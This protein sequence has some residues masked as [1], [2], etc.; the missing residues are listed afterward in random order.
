MF[1]AGVTG[2]S[3]L[4]CLILL[5]ATGKAKAMTANDNTTGHVWDGDLK[6]LNKLIKWERT[7]DIAA[8][9]CKTK[10]LTNEFVLDEG[11]QGFKNEQ[12]KLG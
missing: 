2:V 4:A 3:I 9:V 1:V 7:R 10:V 6:E 12:N 11:G 5:W 8:N